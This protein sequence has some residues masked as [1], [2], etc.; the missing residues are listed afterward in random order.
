[1]LINWQQKLPILWEFINDEE[2]FHAIIINNQGYLSF[3]VRQRTWSYHCPNFCEQINLQ[4]T[5]NP[6]ITCVN[7]NLW[8]LR[9]LPIL[10]HLLITLTYF[11]S[12]KRYCVITLIFLINVIS[13]MAQLHLI[14]KFCFF[15]P[16]KTI[17][18]FNSSFLAFVLLLPIWLSIVEFQK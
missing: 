13:H 12:A 17:V 3:W 4:F 15:R 8:H 14:L 10:R 1:M 7:S 2:H 18:C 16:G 9:I 11:A 6:H 5:I